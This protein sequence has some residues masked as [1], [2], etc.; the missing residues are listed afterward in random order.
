MSEHKE[1]A[2]EKEL[3]DTTPAKNRI[4]GIAGKAN[5]YFQMV[6]FGCMLDMNMVYAPSPDHVAKDIGDGM[7]EWYLD[8][9]MLFEKVRDTRERLYVENTDPLI[10][11]AS[12]KRV[13]KEDGLAIEYEQRALQIKR[14]IQEANPYPKI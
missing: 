14:R 8:N 9:T 6:A 10:S 13:E 4:F 1:Q 5:T 12:M 2:L 11:T 7:G 3:S